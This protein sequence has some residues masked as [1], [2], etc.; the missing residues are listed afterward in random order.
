SRDWS[1]DVCSSDLCFALQRRN[2]DGA[3]KFAFDLLPLAV[4]GPDIAAGDL[5]LELGVGNRDRVIAQ[6]REQAHD[7]VIGEQ[8]GREDPPDA[9]PL[10]GCARGTRCAAHA[11]IGLAHT[12]PAVARAVFVLHVNVPFNAVTVH[13]HAYEAGARASVGPEGARPLNISSIS[14]CRFCRSAN[15]RGLTRCAASLGLQ[16]GEG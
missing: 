9:A 1:S 8:Q 10:A 11:T 5:L 12:F 13:Y 4:D 2:R 3:Q 16:A 14:P 7:E 6:W 15:R